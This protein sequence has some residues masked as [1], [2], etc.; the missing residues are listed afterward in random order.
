MTFND[1]GTVSICMKDYVMEVLQEFPEKIRRKASSPAKNDLLTINHSSPRLNIEKSELFHSLV[2]KLMWVSQRSRL[3]I[4][5][6][7]A[8]LCTR[9][10]VSTEQDMGKLK[11]TLEYLNGTI[12]D[13]LT[14]GATSL[15]ELLNFIDV[16]FAMH[17]DMR[18][19]TGGGASFGRGIFMNMSRKQRI[20]TGST[21]ESEVVGVSDYIPNTIWMMRFLESQ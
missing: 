21:T 10:S 8:F 4:S 3:D 6:T 1:N 12:D 11:R 15:E 9:V 5:T 17:H 16:S 18:S 2:M 7:I 20:N 14:L 19:H 13:I